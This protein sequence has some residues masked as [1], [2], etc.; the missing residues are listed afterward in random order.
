MNA[1]LVSDLFGDLAAPNA[2]QYLQDWKKLL[3]RLGVTVEIIFLNRL[4]RLNSVSEGNQA[5]LQRRLHAAYMHGGLDTA[6]QGLQTMFKRDRVPVLV[7]AFS[8]G[9]YA[10]WL[11]AECLAPK[12]RIAF[13]SSTRLRLISQNLPRLE[14]M[15]TAASSRCRAVPCR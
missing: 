15:G 5:E 11:S 7:I 6:V 1:H 9:G 2:L 10:T 4:A 13:V 12:S 14:T 8:L 3:D